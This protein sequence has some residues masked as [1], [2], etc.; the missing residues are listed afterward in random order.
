MKNIYA[1]LRILARADGI[2]KMGMISR[3]QK[4]MAYKSSASKLSIESKMKKIYC[5]SLIRHQLHLWKKKH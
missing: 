4:Y 5:L 1:H 3:F 2:Y